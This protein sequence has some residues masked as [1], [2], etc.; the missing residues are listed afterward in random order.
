MLENWTKCEF[1]L[2]QLLETRKVE[3]ILLLGFTESTS[4]NTLTR[5]KKDGFHTLTLAKCLNI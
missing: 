3:M 2:G 1:H 4:S 5:L